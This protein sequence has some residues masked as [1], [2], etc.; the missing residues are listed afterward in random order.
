[1]NFNIDCQKLFGSESDGISIIE[2]S[3]KKY[4][5][6]FNYLQVCEIIDAIGISSAN[7]NLKKF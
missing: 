6:V 5:K 7:V 1:M 2:P 3:Q 4:L